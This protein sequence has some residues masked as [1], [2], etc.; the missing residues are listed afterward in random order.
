HAYGGDLALTRNAVGHQG[1]THD[2][3]ALG[4]SGSGGLGLVENRNRTLHPRLGRFL[5]RD[6]LGYVDGMS[7]YEY[8]LSKPTSFSDPFGL[9]S[10]VHPGAIKVYIDSGMSAQQIASNTGWT[11]Q[12]ARRAM[13]AYRATKAMQEAAT[14]SEQKLE[15]NGLG[16]SKQ[17]LTNLESSKHDYERQF[18]ML[19]ACKGSDECP[20]L[21]TKRNLLSIITKL[22]SMINDECY[23][24]GDLG[25]REQLQ[26]K[27]N[28]LRQCEKLIKRLCCD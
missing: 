27:R 2:G 16:C 28:A 6:P 14:Q 21:I 24:G 18:E 1:L 4:L 5:Q 11:L 7:V 13:A 19:G 3:E 8:V 25:H 17:R 12:Q 15:E 22:R 9:Q 20:D 23:Y 10:N 26:G